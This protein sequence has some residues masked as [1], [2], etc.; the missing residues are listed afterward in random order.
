MRGSFTLY[1]SVYD[2]LMAYPPE[3][4]KEA[5][6]LIGEYALDGV[7]PESADGVAYGLFCSVRPLIDKNI[8][9]RDAGAAGGKATASK[10]V[11]NVKQTD[12]K[13]EAKQTKNAELCR[14][15]IDYLNQKAGTKFKSASETTR[16]LVDAR[17][18]EGYTEADFRTVIDKKV[19]EWKGTEWQKFLRPQTLF[20]TKFEGYL[21]Q[22]SSGRGFNNFSQSDTDW[23]AVADAIM[24]VQ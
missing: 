7:L 9:R 13:R 6:R 24:E 23:D 1:R 3:P 8:K 18:A 16:R 17:V 4:M 21:N 12:S 14:S 2:A 20:G 22:R 11:A 19:A 5:L 15:V 10:K